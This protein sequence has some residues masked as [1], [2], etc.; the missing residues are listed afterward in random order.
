MVSPS[1][2]PRPW[3]ETVPTP[4]S[5][6]KFTQKNA[7]MHARGRPSARLAGSK[8]THGRHQ[9]AEGRGSLST[10]LPLPL[11]PA[12]EQHRWPIPRPPLSTPKPNPTSPNLTLP[13]FTQ[14]NSF[15]DP[16]RPPFWTLLGAQIDPRSAPS[17]L[18]TPY[19]FKNVI[20]HQM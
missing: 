7:S 15:L 5:H 4:P 1:L 19:F 11:P 20:F 3:N 14:L 2:F 18:L 13:N 8:T 9:R 6:P 12:L 10:G 16:P 17:R